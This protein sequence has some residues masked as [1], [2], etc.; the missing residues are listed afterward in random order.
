VAKVSSERLFEDLERRLG[1][2]LGCVLC[3]ATSLMVS[4]DVL[5]VDIHIPL[6]QR[7]DPRRDTTEALPVAAVSCLSCG[8]V[9][10]FNTHM[11]DTW[12]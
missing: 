5:E 3:G 12:A 4:D 6:H 10:F 1:K 9:M 2:P 7:R 11:V 8:H